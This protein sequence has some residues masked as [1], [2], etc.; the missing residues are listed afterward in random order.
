MGGGGQ[1]DEHHA[2]RLHLVL[3]LL[4]GGKVQAQGR[5]AWQQMRL[6]SLLQS[7][8]ATHRECNACCN[9][10]PEVGHILRQRFG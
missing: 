7:I 9:S 10:V 3:L 4:Y 5:H 6:S 8:Q 2:R 1:V